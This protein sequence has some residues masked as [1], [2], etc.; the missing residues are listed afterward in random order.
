MEAFFAGIDTRL[1][2]AEAILFSAHY[3][4]KGRDITY[5]AAYGPAG[6]IALVGST[7][8]DD[9]PTAAPTGKLNPPGFDTGWYLRL[10]P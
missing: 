1:S 4:G 9:L 2:G 7:S 10:L 6:E 8:S 3:G 5:G